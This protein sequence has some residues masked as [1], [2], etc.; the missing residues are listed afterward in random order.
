MDALWLES[1]ANIREKW[2]DITDTI[3]PLASGSERDGLEKGLQLAFFIGAVSGGSKP[4]SRGEKVL[5]ALLPPRTAYRLTSPGVPPGRM[6]SHPPSKLNEP[7]KV[8]H[9]GASARQR[10]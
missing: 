1:D 3:R 4:G 5:L 8:G 6:R 7:R 10:S 9:R 2:R